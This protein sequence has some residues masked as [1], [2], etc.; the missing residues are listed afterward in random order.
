MFFYLSKLLWFIVAPTNLTMLA[1]LGA[2]ACLIAQKFRV[3]LALLGIGAA[4]ILL[5]GLLPTGHNLAVFLERHAA[6]LH[7]LPSDIDGIILL[8]GMFDNQLS[9]DRESPQ[10]NASIDRVHAF[11]ALARRY[12]AAAL[13]FTGGTGDIRQIGHSEAIIVRDYLR[14]TG[15]NR[16]VIYEGASR[17]T[18]ENAVNLRAM[19]K[20]KEGHYIL[21]TS[22]TH[23]PRA[24]AVFEG[25][26][27]RVTPYATDYR[28]D[29][30]YRILPVTWR[31]S[32][33]FSL[34]DLAAK[35]IIG[36]LAYFLTG[37]L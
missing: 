30:R 25:Q 22:A 9:K 16:P 8:G 11:R 14:Q 28:T 13:Y 24:K 35:E 32:G 17:N 26:G 37:K 19:L 5:F 4:G 15:F 18:F 2:V 3:G 33:N 12:P 21:I 20:D 6:P 34:S 27:Y 7:N 1:V 29:G 23:M 10:A 36:H 31:F